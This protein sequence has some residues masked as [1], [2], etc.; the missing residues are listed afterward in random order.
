MEETKLE[1]TV[2]D[3]ELGKIAEK[4][5]L[6]FIVAAKLIGCEVMDVIKDGEISLGDAGNLVDL[7]K[8]YKAIIEGFTGLKGVIDG[9]THL[10]GDSIT[11]VIS[12]LVAAVKE[13]LD[14]NK[15]IPVNPAPEVK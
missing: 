9:V 11:K 2:S 6:E 8:N 15:E 5:L 10:E 1:A 4:E 12:E 13:V 7:L 14:R 3:Q